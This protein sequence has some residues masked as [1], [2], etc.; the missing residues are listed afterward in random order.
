M[1]AQPKHTFHYSEEFRQRIIRLHRGKESWPNYHKYLRDHLGGTDS[2]LSWF[3]VQLCPEV[4][5]RCG[6]LENKRVLDFGCGTGSATAPLAMRAGRV[7]A[8][9]IDQESLDICRQRIEEHDLREKVTFH[10]A[11]D[12]LKAVAALGFFDL[13]LINGVLEH[14]P[15]S[16]AGLRRKTLRVLFEMLRRDGCLFIH[17]TPN[18]LWPIDFHST[19]LWWIP[20]MAPGS[21]LAHRLAVA[22][23]RHTQAPTISEGPLGLEEV[24]V[25]GCTYWE[26]TANLRGMEFTC[27]NVLDGQNRHLHY[28]QETRGKRA[29]FERLVYY[30]AVKLLRV[31]ITA[32]APFLTNLVFQRSGSGAPSSSA[33]AN[34]SRGALRRPS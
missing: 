19:Q 23:R 25:W 1:P 29:I 22:R 9:D 21:Q 28:T 34:R 14:I 30:P 32:F 13:I 8:F 16:R 18:R 17:D 4:E 26:I 15:L 7:C 6:A 27:L 33:P 24:G 5:Y 31:P 12:V 20:W 2:R 10:C 11:P 3:G